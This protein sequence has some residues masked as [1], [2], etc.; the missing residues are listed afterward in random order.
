MV[1]VLDG[2][3]ARVGDVGGLCLC[4]YVCFISTWRNV[5]LYRYIV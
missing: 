4:V 1:G 5:A 2:W 3:R